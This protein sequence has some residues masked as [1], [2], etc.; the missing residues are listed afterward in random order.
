MRAIHLR[1]PRS[2]SD[3]EQMVHDDRARLEEQRQFAVVQM[4]IYD[5]VPRTVRDRTKEDTI[6]LRRFFGL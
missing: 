4:A 5:K 2:I 6:H 1:R 3:H